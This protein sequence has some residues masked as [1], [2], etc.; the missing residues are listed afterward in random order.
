[1]TPWEPK[2]KPESSENAYGS[3]PDIPLDISTL[4]MTIPF[5]FGWEI[6]LKS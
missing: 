5:S 2:K 4:S 6:G 1:M 3:T